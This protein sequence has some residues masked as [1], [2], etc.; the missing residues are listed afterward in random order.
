MSKKTE[1]VIIGGGQ[2][3]L[4]TS[5]HLKQRNQEH[6]VLEQSSRVGNAWRNDRWDSFTLLTPNWSFKLPG[7]EY[8]ESEPDGFMAKEEVVRRFD[9]YVSRY[10]LPVQYKVQVTGVEKNSCADGYLVKTGDEVLQSRNVVVAT[11]LYQKARIPSCSTSLPANILQLHSGRYRNP[12]SLP[13]GA[14]LVVGSAQS[15]CQI[16]EELYLSGRKVYLSTGSTG[17]VPRRYR[18]RDIYEW[19]YLGGFLDRTPDKLSSS[20]EKFIANPHVSGRDGGRSLNLHQFARDGVVLLGHIQGADGNRLWFASDL[21]ENLAK[22]DKVE[23]EITGYVDKY[24]EQAGLNAPVEKLPA[25]TDGYQAREITELDLHQAGI[26]TIIWAVG[27][28]FDFSLV[29]LPVFDR[30]NF[31]IQQRGVTAFPGLFFVGLPWLYRQ[32]S[33]HLSGVGEDADYVASAIA[34]RH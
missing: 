2:A 13:P 26:T 5:Y 22:S 4:A 3:G 12:H 33:G 15:G 1:T 20:R 7:A 31:P 9:Q 18:G 8:K 23:T 28:D 10:R 25:L 6:I 27:Y 34:Y 30:D 24:I 32:K 11:G 21:K 19:M 14:V 16:T 17:R 29:N